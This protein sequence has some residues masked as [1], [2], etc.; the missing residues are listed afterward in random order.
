MFGFTWTQILSVVPIF[1]AIWV[2]GYAV[3]TKH[4]MHD[5]NLTERKAM[6][7]FVALLICTALY[8]AIS[9]ENLLSY[10]SIDLM[11]DSRLLRSTFDVLVFYLILDYLHSLRRRRQEEQNDKHNDS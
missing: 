1:M 2:F 7:S 6:R 9:I 11:L 10:T 3:R 4:L 8:I 5:Q